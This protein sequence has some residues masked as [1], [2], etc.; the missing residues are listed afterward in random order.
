M[1]CFI[2]KCDL[3]WLEKVTYE[4]KNLNTIKK[5]KFILP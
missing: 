1:N 4:K 2:N 3:I 5:N